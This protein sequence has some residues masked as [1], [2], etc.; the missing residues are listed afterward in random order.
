MKPKNY[1]FLVVGVVLVLVLKLSNPSMPEH[2]E[3]INQ[4]FKQENS[5][6]GKIAL[7]RLAA[8][9]VA[10]R[11]YHLFSVTTT[12]NKVVSI[13]FLDKVYVLTSMDV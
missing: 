10:Y 7:G 11:D 3:A 12:G 9:L 8:E 2:K 4:K 1:I 6:L 5:I 13:G